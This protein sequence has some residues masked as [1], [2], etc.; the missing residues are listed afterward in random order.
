MQLWKITISSICVWCMVIVVVVASFWLT[1]SYTTC[2]SL[3]TNKCWHNA[4][5]TREIENYIR[6]REKRD[7]QNYALLFAD[8]CYCSQRQL[9]INW[10]IN[11]PHKWN[12]SEMRAIVTTTHWFPYMY[13]CSYICITYEAIAA[14]KF[15]FYQCC[16]LN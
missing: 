5:R 10:T 7:E 13:V 1:R 3:Y 14:S 4:T 11:K 9:K 15:C 12:V 8:G 16:T 2:A 6:E